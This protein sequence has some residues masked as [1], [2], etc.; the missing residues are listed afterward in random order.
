MRDIVRLA[1]RLITHGSAQA[2]AL[3]QVFRHNHLADLA[4]YA[5]GIVQSSDLHFFLAVPGNP[6]A[7]KPFVNL[8]GRA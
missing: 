8:T 7:Q 1:G 6:I 4:I 3:N 2:T 5:D